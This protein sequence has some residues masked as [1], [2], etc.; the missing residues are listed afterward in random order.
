LHRDR[1]GDRGALSKTVLGM[2]L[3]A[4]EFKSGSGEPARD[5]LCRTVIF[6]LRHAGRLGGLPAR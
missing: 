2:R 3:R 6:A 5:F 4:V 1:R